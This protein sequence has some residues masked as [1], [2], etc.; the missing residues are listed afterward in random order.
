M[1]ILE[2][3]RNLSK[4]LEEEQEKNEIQ[5]LILVE[6]KFC[7]RHQMVKCGWCDLKAARRIK[8]NCKMVRRDE[9]KRC[10]RGSWIDSG[11][12]TKTCKFSFVLVRRCS[13]YINVE[14]RVSD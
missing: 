2:I 10:E 3:S 6:V 14:D 12:I 5:F 9:V 8:A 11:T 13:V 7:V 4:R 1:N